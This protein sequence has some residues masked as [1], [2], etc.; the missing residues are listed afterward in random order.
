MKASSQLL[1]RRSLEERVLLSPFVRQGDD[2]TRK[3]TKADFDV[4]T[5]TL[6][7]KGKNKS[8]MKSEHLRKQENKQAQHKGRTQGSNL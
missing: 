6:K 1:L 3:L 8:S 2:L 5:L 7:N 4:Q